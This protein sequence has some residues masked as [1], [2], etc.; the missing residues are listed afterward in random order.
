VIGPAV[1]AAHHVTAP[2]NLGIRVQLGKETE[3]SASTAT[4]VRNV[5]QLLAEVTDFMTLQAGDVLTLGVPHGSPVA[6]AGD[7]A[8][9]AIGTWPALTISFVTARDQ[10]GDKP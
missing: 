8:T 1:V 3:F 2:D 7:T 4:A 9:L 5:A 10:Q 6:H